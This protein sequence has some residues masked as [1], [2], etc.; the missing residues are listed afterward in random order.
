MPLEIRDVVF[1]DR[2]LSSSRTPGI[3]SFDDETIYIE[4]S[5]LMLRF[6]LSLDNH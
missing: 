1:D 5:S 3:R 4:W 2:F 6:I